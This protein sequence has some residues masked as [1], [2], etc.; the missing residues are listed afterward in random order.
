MN[1]SSTQ[2]L[3]PAPGNMINVISQYLLEHPMLG[4]AF[5]S[6]PDTAAIAFLTQERRIELISV[7]PHAVPPLLGP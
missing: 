4:G 3:G 7:L 2:P 1:L 5:L 6:H